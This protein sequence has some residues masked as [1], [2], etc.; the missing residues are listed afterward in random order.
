M[1]WICSATVTYYIAIN[2]QITAIWHVSFIISQLYHPVAGE[3]AY[4]NA[5]Y[6]PEYARAAIKNGHCLLMGIKQARASVSDTLA[7]GTALGMMQTDT[8]VQR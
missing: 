1:H 5:K 8:E 7:S 6:A 3:R 4:F 2:H